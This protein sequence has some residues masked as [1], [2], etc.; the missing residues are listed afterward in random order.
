MPFKL[1]NA[2]RKVID[3]ILKDM[4]SENSMRRLLQGDVGSGKTIVA[5]IS[6]LNIVRNGYQAVLMAPTSILAEQHFNTFYQMAK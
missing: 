2:Q 4:S 5:L 6:M 1:T 3:A